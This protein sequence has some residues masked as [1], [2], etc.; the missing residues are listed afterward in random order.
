[1]ITV[2]LE[3]S[4][5]EELARVA[6]QGNGRFLCQRD[7]QQFPLLSQVDECSFSIF[8][9]ADMVA[10]IVELARIRGS[11]PGHIDEIILLAERCSQEQGT[12][13][14]FTPFE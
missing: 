11:S 7:R 3:T 6:E 10:L 13:L 8:G 4:T 14:A 5:D 9:G 1:M 12:T 2:I